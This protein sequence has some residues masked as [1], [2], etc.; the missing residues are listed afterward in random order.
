[1]KRYL[2][3]AGVFLGVATSAALRWELNDAPKQAPQQTGDSTSKTGSKVP[4]LPPLDPEA[5]KETA[6]QNALARMDDADQ[7]AIKEIDESLKVIEQFFAQRKE[8]SKLFAADVLG[9]KGKWEL[10]RSKLPGSEVDT[11]YQ[12]LLQ[13]F[14]EHLFKGKD[15]EDV[16]TAAVAAHLSSLDGIDNQLLVNLRTDI[17]ELRPD[18]H[19]AISS[20]QS[21]VAFREGYQAAQLAVL[22]W[23][24][25]D[26]RVSIATEVFSQ[27]ASTIATRIAIRVVVGVATRLGIS[28]GILGTGVMAT[29]ATL[30]LSLVVGIVL[31]RV[32]W[33]IIRRAGHDPEGEIAKRVDV[34][35]DQVRDALIDGHPEAVGVYREALKLSQSSTFSEVQAEANK[36]ME[37]LEQTGALGLRRELAVYTKARNE[38]RRAALKQLILGNSPS[39][40]DLK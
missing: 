33:E 40:G 31:D 35:I 34:A 22:P 32:V 14:E 3:L 18:A 20:V 29:G 2:I 21:D 23:M 30:G 9:L 5:F 17:A 39:Q 13:K 36:T 24:N 25:R 4:S 37:V 12:F 28:V 8:G 19:L 7:Q 38:Q 16:L 1:M 15:V 26:L 6:W 10:L 27:V 11:H